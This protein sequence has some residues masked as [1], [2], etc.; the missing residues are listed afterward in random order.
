MKKF[1]RIRRL[2]RRSDY[3]TALIHY[4]NARR[5]GDIAGA[6]RWIKLADM[7]LRLADRFDEGVHAAMIREA[8][9]EEAQ[10]REC[11]EKERLSTVRAQKSLDE[12]MRE[13]EESWSLKKR[14]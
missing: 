11:A 3:E 13:F 4:R 8:E 5:Q 7:H 1:K 2:L 14:S 9:R 6:Q 10:A 12:H